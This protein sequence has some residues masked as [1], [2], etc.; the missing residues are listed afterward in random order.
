MFLVTSV[1]QIAAAPSPVRNT[2]LATQSLVRLTVSNKSG[3]TIYIRLEG[4]TIYILPVPWYTGE[5]VTFTVKRGL[6]KY[7]FKVCGITATGIL[8][9]TK[10]QLL[11]VPVCRYHSN[12]AKPDGNIRVDVSPQVR[13]VAVTI[14]NKGNGTML[15]IL[16][17]PT[18]YAFWIYAGQTAY[19]TITKGTYSVEYRG[20]GSS[21]T[22]S[23][24]VYHG[25]K[26]SL[27]C[28]GG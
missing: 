1:L 26:L 7:S 2:S 17:G 19:Y 18:Y 25:S 11:I 23:W 5:K 15:V 13:I 22:T 21:D 16:S 9:M 10:Q 28:P 20:C 3:E 27:F 24:T 8:D 14:T 6:Y 12:K 4:P